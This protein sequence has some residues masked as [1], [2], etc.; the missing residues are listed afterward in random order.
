[1]EHATRYDQLRFYTF[2]CL[3]GWNRNTKSL[4][5]QSVVIEG[6]GITHVLKM[7]NM[8]VP[9]GSL[10]SVLFRFLGSLRIADVKQKR[11]V[12]LLIDPPT[13]SFNIARQPA[14]NIYRSSK[15]T[16]EI[17]RARK[18]IARKSK[19]NSPSGFVNSATAMNAPT[20]ATSSTINNQRRNFGAL[21]LRRQHWMRVARRV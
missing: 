17:I 5:P 19:R 8:N 9:S 12:S 4:R 6:C 21:L 15:S 7:A 13:H 20:N 14:I 3:F 2:Y 18:S 16:H 10:H 1:M 11:W